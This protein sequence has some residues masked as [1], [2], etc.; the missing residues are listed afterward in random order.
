MFFTLCSPRS[1]KPIGS[2]S[3]TCSRTVA[4]TQISARLGKGSK[5]CSNVDAIAENVIALDDHVTHVDSDA[6]ADAVTFIDVCISAFDS[7][8]DDD[9]AAHR[10]DNRSELDKKTVACRLEDAALVL[11][12]QRIDKLPA[13]G[14]QRGER[15][16]LVDTHEARVSHHVRGE[17]RGQPARG[18]GLCVHAPTLRVAGS[19]RRPQRS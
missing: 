12:D 15:P 9:G 6:K 3:A 5:P 4:L 17:N 18:L 8:L 19:S 1:A 14:L 11:G 2:F 16:F 7:L 13:V 10:I